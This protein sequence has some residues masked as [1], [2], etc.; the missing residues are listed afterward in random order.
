M[1]HRVRHVVAA[2]VAVLLAMGAAACGDDGPDVSAGAA[3]TLHG[4]IQLARAAAAARDRDGARAA[5]EHLERSVATLRADGQITADARARID[6]AIAHARAELTSIPTTTTTTTTTTTR[7]EHGRDKERPDH[8][9]GHEGR[10]GADD[11]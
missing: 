5:L 6:A 8:G 11:Q 10:G 7:P 2:V 3:R 9:K 4:G 1:R